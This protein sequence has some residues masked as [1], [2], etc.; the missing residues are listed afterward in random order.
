MKNK[1]VLFISIL[2]I[3]L[4]GIFL[5]IASRPRTDVVLGAFKVSEDGKTIE[6]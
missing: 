3:I 5:I 6:L 1:K 4:L 2:I